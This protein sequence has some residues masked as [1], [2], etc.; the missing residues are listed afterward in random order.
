L[1]WW[2]R[3]SRGCCGGGV[4]TGAAAGEN[5]SQLKLHIVLLSVELNLLELCIFTLVYF[6]SCDNDW[7]DLMLIQT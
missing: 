7:L 6:F 5:P 3:C 1:F 2:W 4:V